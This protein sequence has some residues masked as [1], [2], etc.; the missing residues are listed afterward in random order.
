MIT[1]LLA[2]C[3]TRL[4]NA[5]D[6]D[7]PKTWGTPAADSLMAEK[8]VDENERSYLVPALRDKGFAVSEGKRAYDKR[9][10]FSP[11]IGRLGTQNLFA[12]RVAFNPNS[13]LG[14]E[15]SLGHNPAASL[16]AMLHT[17][18]VIVRYPLPWRAQ[19]YAT[20]GYGMMTVYPGQALNAD[21][22][23]K[24]AVLAGGGL[25]FYIRDDI[26]LRGELR[27]T[28]IF[29]QEL[30]SENTVAYAYREFTIG[31]AFYRHLG[32]HF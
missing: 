19:P 7:Q 11:A 17:F 23:S 26:A 18:N 27:G 3:A 8:T 15:V 16:H 6:D 28:T 4:A 24:N 30:G 31:F 12:F 2:V 1:L 29:G 25:E 10:A 13:W 20:I 9:L 22:V 5:G 14:Y 32:G 21:P